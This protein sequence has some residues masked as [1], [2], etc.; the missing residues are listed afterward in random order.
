MASFQS[1]VDEFG[2]VLVVMACRRIYQNLIPGP[3]RRCTRQMAK[4]VTFNLFGALNVKFRI[5]SVDVIS[6]LAVAPSSLE[7]AVAEGVV[8]WRFGF[9]GTRSGRGRR[10]GC[11]A[12]GRRGG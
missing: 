11:P 12:S 2:V 8:E 5:S 7:R 4:S 1:G 6:L 10:C 3:C 9:F